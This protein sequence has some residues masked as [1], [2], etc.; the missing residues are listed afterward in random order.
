MVKS[1]ACAL[2]I[3]CA[4]SNKSAA[5]LGFELAAGLRTD[6]ARKHEEVI[7]SQTTVLLGIDECLDVN[8]VALLVLVLEHLERLGEVQGVGGG[9]DH[10]VSVLDGHFCK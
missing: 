7:V 5:G 9:V 10:G 6:V 3:L 4:H 1:V 8:A 2:Q